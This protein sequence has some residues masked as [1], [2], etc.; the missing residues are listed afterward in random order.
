METF[1]H[2]LQWA[3]PAAILLFLLRGVCRETKEAGRFNPDNGIYSKS[4]T[5]LTL[6]L[7]AAGFI[8]GMFWLY[9]P[10]K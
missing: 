10:G 4:V 7:I 8:L 6:F 3:V 2:I 1:R 5:F 9:I